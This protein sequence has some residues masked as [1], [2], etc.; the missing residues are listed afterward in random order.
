P[1]GCRF[2]PRCPD[3]TGECEEIDPQ[4]RAVAPGHEVA[5]IRA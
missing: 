4:L 5:C 3:A 1:A 2:H